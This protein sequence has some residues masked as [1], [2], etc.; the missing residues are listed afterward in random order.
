VL[1]VLAPSSGPIITGYA[2]MLIVVLAIWVS[3]MRGLS[4]RW[5]TITLPVLIWL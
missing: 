3:V 4:R 2:L 1:G 5:N